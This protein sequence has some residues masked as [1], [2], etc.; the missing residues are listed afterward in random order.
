MLLRKT[1][2]NR[3]FLDKGVRLG[4]FKV[5][6]DKTKGYLHYCAEKYG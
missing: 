3:L 4:G 1:P 2:Y 6:E 5:Y